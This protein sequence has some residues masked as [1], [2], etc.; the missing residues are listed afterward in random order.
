MDG[1][2]SEKTLEN[3]RQHQALL[4]DY[5]SRKKGRSMNLPTDDRTIQFR[6]RE[7]GEPI[8]LF[9]ERPPERRDRYRLLLLSR[10]L[11]DSGVSLSSQYGYESNNELF[12]TEG[13]PALRAARVFMV[14]YSLPRSR[15]RIEVSKRKREEEEKY[16]DERE[17]L[18]KEVKAED[19][20][21]IKTEDSSVMDV[22][23]LVTSSY[24]TDT[25]L[26]K[27]F[28]NK[29]SSF[30]AVSSVVGDE[31]P[32]AYVSFS[33]DGKNLAT[34][35]WTGLCKIWNVENGEMVQQLRGHT[36]QAKCI[37][38]QETGNLLASASADKTAMLWSP[39]AGSPLAVLRGHTDRVN[40][41]CFHPSGR[42]LAS[43][44]ADLSWK[45]WDVETHK[46]LLDQEGHSRSVRDIAF[47]PDGSLA[48][49][50]G[51]DKIGRVWDIRAGKSVYVFRG[52]SSRI[53]SI[54]FSSNGYQFASASDDNTVRIWD[55][56]KRRTMYTVPAHTN[57]VTQTIKMW[58]T[59]DFSHI[60]TLSGASKVLSVDFT[61][62]IDKI[63]A[64]SYDTTWKIYAHD[65]LISIGK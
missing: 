2:F 15:A 50:G 10:G 22:D 52:H 60:K 48:A 24:K 13:T 38:Y 7:L 1:G 29:F 11:E 53:L 47:H 21:V 56:R 3:Q 26:R 36:D 44:S 19:G 61:K 25:V 46:E 30:G 6:L 49:S 20:T 28:E 14:K 12:H 33:P 31:R 63:A 64:A 65:D 42:F 62:T 32:L 54:D 4:N 35:S 8:I 55:L 16:W 5:E 39:T 43:A 41:V 45:L 17:K 34:S 59:R 27:E 18:T 23:S 37:V 51:E 57:S 9:G 58:L 40:R